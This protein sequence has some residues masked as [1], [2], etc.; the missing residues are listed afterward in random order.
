MYGIDVLLDEDL[1]PHVLEVQWGP[2][3]AKALELR[4]SFWDEILLALY[5]N[6][7]SHVV[8]I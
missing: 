4:P 3:C 8:K 6:D 1:Q 5:A 7:Y 2:D